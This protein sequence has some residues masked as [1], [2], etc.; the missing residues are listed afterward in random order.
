MKEA[1][2]YVPCLRPSGFTS[3]RCSASTRKRAGRSPLGRAHVLPLYAPPLSRA[4]RDPLFDYWRLLT[5]IKRPI[6]ILKSL[7]ARIRDFRK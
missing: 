4:D 5:T 1:A 6:N 7:I 2:T 3:T